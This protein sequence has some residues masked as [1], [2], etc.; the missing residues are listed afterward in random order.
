ME[1]IIR[2][3]KSIEPDERRVYEGVLGHT[4]QEN[5][6]VL[7]IVLEP[8]AEPDESAR[9]KAMDEFHALCREGTEHRQQL[10]VS[11][12]E[13]DRAYEEALRAVRAGKTG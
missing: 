7:V 11:V 4:L 9:R 3:V 12:E 1:S 10:G 5:Q 6:R 13:A 8:G 2:D